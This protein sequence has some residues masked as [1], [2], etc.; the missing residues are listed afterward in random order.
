MLNLETLS[1]LPLSLDEA[2]QIVFGAGVV[3]EETKVRRLDELT[4]VALDQAACRGSQEIVYYMY[5]GIYRQGDAPQLAGSPLRYELTLIPPRQIGPEFVKTFGHLHNAHPQSGMTYAEIC[6][7]LVG[8]AH[9]LF[10]TLDVAGPDASLAFYMEVKAGEK[11]IIPP[12]VDHLAINPGPGPL[13]FSDMIFLEVTGIYDRFKAS[14]GAAYLEVA[15]EDRQAQ[16]I[17]NPGYRTVPSLQRMTP[18]DYPKLHLTREEPLYTAFVQGRGNPEN[19]S[20]L[21]DPRQFWSAFPDLK[22]EF[23]IT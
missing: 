21:T 14:R 13:L 6:E 23:E 9:F 10:Q 17:P 7:V 3:V 20:F 2:G 16:F 8:T 18:K 22:A 5:N 11:V 19:W 4:P 15:S 12:D 1:G